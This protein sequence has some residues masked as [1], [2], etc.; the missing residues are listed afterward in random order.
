[1]TKLNERGI[2]MVELLAA[3]ILVSLI[4]GVSWTA[5]SIGLKYTAVETGKTEIQQDANIFIAKL[6]SIHRQSDQYEIKFE[7]D[8]FMIRSKDKDG[9]TDFQPVLDQE[10]SFDGTSINEVIDFNTAYRIY[11]KQAHAKLKLSLK[12]DNQSIQV[13]TTLTRIRTDLP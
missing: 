4:V 2:T 6:S 5:L 12:K 10:Y 9:W 8:Q 1:M 11:P 7:N 13:Q 3:L